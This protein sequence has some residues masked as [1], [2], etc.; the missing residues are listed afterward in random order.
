MTG[1]GRSTSSDQWDIHEHVAAIVEIEAKRL[2]EASSNAEIA[3]QAVDAIADANPTLANL[4]CLFAESL[5][6]LNYRSLVESSTP[7]RQIGERQWY[8]TSI[9]ANEWVLWNDRDLAVAG[10]FESLDSAKRA[11]W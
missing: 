3:K 10:V 11:A 1:T 8:A 2:L 7:A 9:R 6:F 4:Q 5:G